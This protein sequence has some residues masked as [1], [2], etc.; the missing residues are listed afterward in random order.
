MENLSTIIGNME[1]T[2]TIW[3]S[4]KDWTEKEREQQ[5]ELI[6]KQH[7][8]HSN[9]LITSIHMEELLENIQVEDGEYIL[10][11]GRE[12]LQHNS[13]FLLDILEALEGTYLHLSIQSEQITPL[14]LRELFTTYLHPIKLDNFTLLTF[15][16]ILHLDY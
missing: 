13:I 12:L 16:N 15:W 1:Q 3:V 2:W 7:L 8:S 9:N 6:N 10:N 5:K 4:E 11:I 14:Q